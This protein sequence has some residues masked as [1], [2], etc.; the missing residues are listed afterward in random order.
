MHTVKLKRKR[1][2]TL[3]TALLITSVVLASMTSATSV[4]A[5]TF[6]EVLTPA[7][8]SQILSGAQ[9]KRERA[10]PGSLWPEISVFQRVDAAPEE[11]VAIFFDFS[12]HSSIF[13]D[14]DGTGIIKSEISRVVDNATYEVNYILRDKAAGIVI[15]ENYIAANRL[16]AVQSD[17][18][19]VIGYKV[20]WNGVR[21]SD[22]VQE[23][24]GQ[25]YV[26]ALPSG[27]SLIAYTNFI[28]PKNLPFTGILK[29]RAVERVRKTVLSLASA[30][31][32]ERQN[33]PDVLQRQ[34]EALKQALGQ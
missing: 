20:V 1:G 17:C 29:P 32:S 27:G 11:V 14:A 15:N 12:I 16:S 7:E 30:T 13:Q 24:R 22:M 25:L 10:I 6:D 3:K 19:D 2:Y 9:V 31:I 23:L 26:E 4:F 34:V 8:Q 18:G 33:T 21:T 28:K 5:G